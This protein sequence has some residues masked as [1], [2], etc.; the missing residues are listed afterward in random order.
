M[1]NGNLYEKRRLRDRFRDLVT[2]AAFTLAVAA[3][4]VLIM[5]LLVYPVTLFA[6]RNKETFNFIVRDLSLFGLLAIILIAVGLKIR[7]LKKEGLP[8]KEIAGYLF[9]KPFYY[10]SIF[11]FFIVISAAL[12]FLLYLLFSNNYYLLYKLTSS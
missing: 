5:N 11:F 1:Y 4:S 7:H 9:R 12:L 2:L 10:L 6:V 3:V 8:E